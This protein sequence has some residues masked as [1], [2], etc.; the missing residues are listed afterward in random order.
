MKDITISEYGYIGCDNISTQ[1]NKFVGVRDLSAEEF[2]EL[3]DFWHEDKNTQKVLTFENKEC[4]KATSYVGVIQTENLS[5]EIL[6][7]IYNGEN[8]KKYRHIFMEML[9]PL[10]GINEIEIHRANLDTTKNKNIYELFITL[11]IDYVD[12]LIHKGLKSEYISQEG[13]QAFLKGK[14]KFNEHI[15][16][17]TIHKERFYVEY[18]EY[19]QDRVEN[20][21]L[22]STL[23]F[24]LK[25]SNNVE[26]KRAL[27]QQ[28]FIF[29]EVNFSHNHRVDFTKV[30]THRGMEY[31]TM[32]IRFAKVFLL[33]ESFSSL[34]GTHDIFALLFP[35]Q[36][37]FEKYM[38]FVLENSKES[39]GIK[40]VHI[41][42]RENEY[43]LV[44]N[45]ARLQPDYLLEMNNG[46]DIICDAKWKLL[47]H[48]E[49]ETKEC[50]KVNIS[51]SDVYQIFAYHHFYEAR[52][53][54]Y[55]FVPAI[56]GVNRT[57]LKY[58]KS[59]KKIE[60]I[61]VEIDSLVK[62]GHSYLDL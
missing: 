48:Q 5:I 8:E 40:K 15:R 35:M 59:A 20:R 37:V 21:L 25:K 23:Q 31:Y 2:Q 51:S 14:L 17:N 22:K 55:V 13:N 10:L 29:D 53:T 54:A 9:K 61:P 56:D 27:R 6:P 52:D 32:P 28:L 62:N 47:D 43:L 46:K 42:G 24:L 36:T 49:D 3:Y 60:V 45:M 19:V 39:L 34:R 30:N 58:N 50:Q 18:D 26:N 1:N 38:E 57:V 12:K 44:C 16:Y 7:K 4:L 11:F 41:N 33:H